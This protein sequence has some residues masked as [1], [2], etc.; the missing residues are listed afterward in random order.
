M[1]EEE[2]MQQPRN[3]R[4]EFENILDSQID[5]DEQIVELKTDLKAALA[6][7]RSVN[8]QHDRVRS[9]LGNLQVE[10]D[11][12]KLAI[13]QIDSE[14]SEVIA[15]SLIDGSDFS[16]DDELLAHRLDLQ[17][18]VERM[19]IVRPALER[20]QRQKY[21]AIELAS[22]PCTTLEDQINHRRDELKLHE[23]RRRHGYE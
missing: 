8:E 12:A 16:N 23:A 2:L 21:R 20:H 1:T 14:R 18:F 3:V 9:I 5:A 7:S 6:N 22:N 11:Q 15:A 4:E 10:I 19:T 13:E 17:R